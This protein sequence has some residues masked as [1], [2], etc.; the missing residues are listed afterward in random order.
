[1]DSLRWVITGTPRSGTTWI[2]TVLDHAGLRTGHEHSVRALGDDP[3]LLHRSN[4]NLPGESSYLAAPYVKQLR[5]AGSIVVHL[6]RPPLDAIGSMLG[7]R[8]NLDAA[9]HFGEAV[10]LFAPRFLEETTPA[11]RYARFWLDWNELIGHDSDMLWRLN[12][13]RQEHIEALAAWA[14]HR[15]FW[16]E[17]FARIQVPNP[18][19]HPATIDRDDLGDSLWVEVGETAERYAVPLTVDINHSS[20]G[21]RPE[22]CPI[23]P[24][25]QV[26]RIQTAIE[27][28]N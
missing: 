5:Q 2:G 26:V 16:S 19:A 13:I 10:R 17:P 9:N 22:D 27:R 7:H 23:C 15:T 12:E 11:R 24:P 21:H 6:V 4:Q 18:G 20:E 28:A 1:M 8:L 14:G 25:A 3:W